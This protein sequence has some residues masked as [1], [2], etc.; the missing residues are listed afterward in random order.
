MYI[1]LEPN[2]LD[3]IMDVIE[4]IEKSV[5]ARKMLFEATTDTLVRLVKDKT[6]NVE[7]CEN[8]VEIMN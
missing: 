5:E 1:L 8:A 6:E 4:V 2:R 7:L 3:E